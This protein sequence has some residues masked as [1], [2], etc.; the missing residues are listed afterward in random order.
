V[1]VPRT[2]AKADRQR[3]R[4]A[5]RL[6]A[7]RGNQPGF[8]RGGPG[9]EVPGGSAR[10]HEAL[11]VSAAGISGASRGPRTECLSSRLRWPGSGSVPAW[12]EPTPPHRP[13]RPARGAGDSRLRSVVRSD[14]WSS[15]RLRCCSSFG[16]GAAALVARKL[17]IRLRR[18][19]RFG[20]GSMRS[21]I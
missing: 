11:D 21:N 10:P 14:C 20:A 6:S 1:F 5:Q 7:H 12:T 3:A 8:G 16:N 15:W 9:R 19:W 17:C 13:L 4:G 2:S 18:V